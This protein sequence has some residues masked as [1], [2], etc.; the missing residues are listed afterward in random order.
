MGADTQTTGVIRC[1][2]PQALDIGSRNSRK[3]ENLSA[4]IVDDVLKWWCYRDCFPS[5]GT[6]EKLPA[7]SFLR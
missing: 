2:Q 5:Y 6:S 1:D 7:L 3:T 4:M